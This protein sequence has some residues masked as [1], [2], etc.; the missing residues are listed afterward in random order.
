L[1][2]PIALAAIGW[3]YYFVFVAILICYAVISY[4]FYPE[5]KGYSLEHMAILFD[6]DDAPV[7]A[8]EK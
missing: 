2:N 8:D 1:V 6:G 4:F 5:T 3:R 7:P